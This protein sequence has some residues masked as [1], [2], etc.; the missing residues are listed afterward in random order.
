M[1]NEEK[2]IIKTLLNQISHA[3]YCYFEKYYY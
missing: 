2:N 3:F 1:K